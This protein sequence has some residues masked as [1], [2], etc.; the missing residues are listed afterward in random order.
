M[1]AQ[2]KMFQSRGKIYYISLYVTILHFLIH[3]G[4]AKQLITQTNAYVYVQT[5]NLH[6]AT[7]FPSLRTALI[8]AEHLVYTTASD[9]KN[10]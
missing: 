2:T 10:Y 9:D 1:L 4:P 7:H 5:F 8:V 3:K 6:V